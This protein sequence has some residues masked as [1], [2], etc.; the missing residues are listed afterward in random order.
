VEVL[1]GL[2]ASSSG[3][4]RAVRNRRSMVR[5]SSTAESVRSTARGVP[6]GRAFTSILSSPC[7]Y[8]RLSITRQTSERLKV[9]I[10][11]TDEIS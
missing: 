2:E 8:T 11:A 10:L 7:S 4:A 6:V 3:T 1:V 5:W 9:E